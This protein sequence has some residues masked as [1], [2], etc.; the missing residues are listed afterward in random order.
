MCKTQCDVIFSAISKLFWFALFMFIGCGSVIAADL[1]FF[2]ANHK[3]DSRSWYVS[4]GWANGNYQSCEWRADALSASGEN[5]KFTVSN[6][7]GKIRPIGCGEIRTKTA[8]SYGT[9]EARIKTVAGTGLNTAFFTYVGYPSK[10]IH[11]EIDFEFLGKEPTMV[12]L[13]YWVDGKPDPSKTKIKLGFDASKGFHDYKFVW[14]PTKISWFV[15]GKLVHETKDGAVMPTHPQNLFMSLWT[16]SKSISQW[17][18]TFAYKS[19]VS[20]EFEW[21]KFTPYNKN[22]NKNNNTKKK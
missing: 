8:Y 19:P 20:A 4:N 18:G 5:L 14:T 11:D 17:M 15:D 6:K 12:E 22:N 21:V 1:P 16:S 3:I 7:G 9:Y 13:N 10:T 2:Y